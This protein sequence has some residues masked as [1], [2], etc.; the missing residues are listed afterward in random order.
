MFGQSLYG[1]IEVLD[2]TSAGRSPGDSFDNLRTSR[3]S[4]ARLRH[5]GWGCGG[6]EEFQDH[7]KTVS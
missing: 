1:L 6:L 3:R 2:M 7:F 5:A 4:L